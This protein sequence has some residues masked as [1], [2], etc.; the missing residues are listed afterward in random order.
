MGTSPRPA[1]VPSDTASSCDPSPPV[2]CPICLGTCA[3][4]FD[5]GAYVVMACTDCGH[6]FVGGEPSRDHLDQIYGDNYFFGGGDGYPDYMAEADLLIEHGR[7]FAEI[8]APHAAPGRM[9][10][11]GAAAGFLLEGFVEAG[12]KGSGIEPNQRMAELGRERRGL[13]VRQGDLETFDTDTPFDLVTM[14]QVLGHFHDLPAAFRTVDRIT[15]PGGLC[16]VDYW[17]RDSRVARLMGHG[18]HE[19]SPPSVRHWF[20]PRDLDLAFSNIGF[21]PVARGQPRKYLKGAHLKSLAGHKLRAS[22]LTRPLAPLLHV[23]PDA[24]RLRYPAFDLAWVLY[25]KTAP[26]A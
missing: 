23:I 5:I 25:R 8:V 6:R 12:W 3:P 16:L 1:A 11:V 10:D 13:D 9:L 21:A 24:M 2:H 20:G 17:N 7:R 26:R 4:A 22:P 15:A 14:I 18:W 19:Y